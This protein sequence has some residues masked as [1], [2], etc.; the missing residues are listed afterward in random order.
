MLG[1]NSSKVNDLSHRTGDS[2]IFY[3]KKGAG[4]LDAFNSAETIYGSNNR[5][6]IGLLDLNYYVNITITSSSD[7]NIRSALIFENSENAILTSNYGNNLNLYLEDEN[8]QTIES[9]TSTTNIF[10]TLEGTIPANESARLRVHRATYISSGSHMSFS[11]FWMY[12]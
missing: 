11:C 12:I 10:E 8:N 5:I 1:A 4:F 2:S 6:K 9:S 7:Y 3:N